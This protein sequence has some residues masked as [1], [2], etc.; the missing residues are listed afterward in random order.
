MSI[1]EW[2]PISKAQEQFLALP[3]KIKEGF[4]GGGAGPGKSEILF[5]YPIVH[6]FYKHPRFKALFMRRTYSELKLEIIPRSRYY[7]TAFGGHFNKS[8]LVWEFSSGEGGK[9]GDRSLGSVFFGHCENEADV[10]RYDSMEINLFLPDEVQTLTEYI[11][12]YIGFER[13]RSGVP[14]LPAIIR[15]AGMPG[16]VGHTFV[17][18][19]FIKHARRGGKVIEGKGGNLRIFIFSTLADNTKIDPNYAQSLEMMPEAEKRAKKY[20]DWDSYE[21]QVF[22][23]FRDR[24]YPGEPPHAVHIIPRFDIPAWWPRIVVI[25]WGFAAWNYVTFTAISPTGRAYVYREMAWKRTKINVWSPYVKE[26]L[27][28]ENVKI[29]KVCKSAGQDRGLDHTIQQQIEEALGRGVILTTNSPGSRV[30]GKSLLHEYLRWEQRYVPVKEQES[31]DEELAM[32]ILRNHG[33]VAYKTYKQR[34]ILVGP[35]ENIPKLQIFDK[36]PE[37]KEITLL[38]DA[39]KSCNY[40]KTNPEDVAEFDGDDPYDNI[41]YVVDCVDHYIEESAAEFKEV[42]ARQE[43]VNNFEMTKDWNALFR[44]AQALEKNQST[45]LQ[46]VARYHRKRLR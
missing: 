2:K 1:T 34:F 38:P 42:Q 4:F 17:K 28:N 23:E 39:I 7:Y 46:P 18:N 45:Y 15:G 25:D 19:R 14:E 16:N 43:L 35:E 10:H 29:I 31:Y 21:G 30:A 24:N 36:S 32:W 41:R 12:L 22:E 27:D 20:G 40:D 6:E 9:F 26:Y 5:M 3:Y 33:E 44:Q 13:V 8:D 11:Y 37:G